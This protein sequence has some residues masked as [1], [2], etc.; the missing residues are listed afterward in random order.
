MPLAV[1]AAFFH[2]L[3][4]MPLWLVLLF[5]VL[6]TIAAPTWMW[7][8]FTGYCCACVRARARAWRAV[9]RL[10]RRPYAMFLRTV[11]WGNRA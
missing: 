8:V 11:R 3:V 1:F 2:L 10:A 9:I 4:T 6:S 5:G 7:V